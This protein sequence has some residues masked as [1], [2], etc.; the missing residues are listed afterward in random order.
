ML[1][2]L[3]STALTVHM[4]YKKSSPSYPFQAVCNPKLP[5]S[6]TNLALTILFHSLF[7]T[8]LLV[9]ISS[10]TN[11]TL[12]KNILHTNNWFSLS[13]YEFRISPFRYRTVQAVCFLI[14]LIT[15]TLQLLKHSNYELYPICQTL[16]Y[17]KPL[18]SKREFLD[19]VLCF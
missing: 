7:T 2:G 12:C 10:S 13:K 5:N 6:E 19:E 11:N 14:F 1:Y 3:S 8:Q 16:Y 4:K 18:N 15:Y 17:I 9:S